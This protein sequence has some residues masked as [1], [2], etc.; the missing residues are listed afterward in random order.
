MP[1]SLPLAPSACILN[2]LLGHRSEHD[3]WN[4]RDIDA[5]GVLKSFRLPM[6]LLQVFLVEMDGVKT[7]GGAANREVDVGLPA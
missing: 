2:L 1:E 7:R 6:K 5:V 4:T 3:D